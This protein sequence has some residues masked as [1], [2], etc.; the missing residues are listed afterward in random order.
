[1]PIMKWGTPPG[2]NA[3]DRKAHSAGHG[4]NVALVHAAFGTKVGGDNAQDTGNPDHGPAIRWSTA[5]YTGPPIENV[6]DRNEPANIWGYRSAKRA[7]RCM[8]NDDTCK[9][10]ATVK[11]DGM[12]CNAHGRQEQG[13]PAWPPNERPEA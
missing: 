5:P 7:R 9:A 3:D 6:E 12:Y 11:Y 1:M 13:L 2:G 4:D 8:G 10:W